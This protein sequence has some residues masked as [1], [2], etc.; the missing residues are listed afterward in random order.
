M[1]GL[2]KD[3]KIACRSG[4]LTLAQT[5]GA[6]FVIYGSIAKSKQIFPVCAMIDAIVAY[7]AKSLGII[8]LVKN[9]PLYC[10][11]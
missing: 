11:F 4:A 7:H 9:H 2:E 5:A 1:K 8:P 6:N 10:M 3:T